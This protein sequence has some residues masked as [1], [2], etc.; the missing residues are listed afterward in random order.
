MCL[1]K[2]P[3]ILVLVWAL[4][5]RASHSQ[6][7]V[8]FE[9]YFGGPESDGAT[10]LIAVSDGGFLL[11]GWKAQE[12]QSSIKDGWLVRVDDRGRY[13]WDLPLLTDGT[14]G[15]MA[16]SPSLDGGYWVVTSD[17]EQPSATRLSK[18]SP[19]GFLESSRTI[20]SRAGF[21]VNAAQ[22]TLDGGLILA[23]QIRASEA[24]YGWVVKLDR[25][26]DIQWI[27]ALQRQPPSEYID[28]TVLLTGESVA[29]GW[30][31][32]PDGQRLGWVTK[33]DSVGATQWEQSYGLEDET[34]IQRILSLD[35][36]SLVFLANSMNTD[37]SLAKVMIG[38][39]ESGGGLSWQKSISATSSAL[40][41]DLARRSTVPFWR[42][43]PSK[44]MTGKT[45]S[46]SPL[47]RMARY[48][49]SSVTAAHSFRTPVPLQT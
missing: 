33:L 35:D 21:H 46:W 34:Y 31:T 9:S 23:G 1:K 48:S 22:P 44:M 13:V 6:D 18:V 37:S 25:N 3:C 38:V 8:E 10:A 26:F 11:G 27:R 41:H 49:P 29:V 42:R 28:V 36:G 17:S 4:L 2:L 24:P 19:A 47:R 16:L 7:R 32:G 40:G 12:G 20:D 45:A 30:I 43:R 39:L 15:V 14:H 5:P